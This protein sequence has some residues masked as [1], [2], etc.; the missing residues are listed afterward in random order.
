MAHAPS[1]GDCSLTFR[2]FDSIAEL[3]SGKGDL[4]ARLNGRTFPLSPDV[5]FLGNVGSH[6]RRENSEFSR[7]DVSKRQRTV[8]TSVK[9]LPYLELV[10]ETRLESAGPRGNVRGDHKLQRVAGAALI[11]LIRSGAS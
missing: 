3:A 7:I 11:D 8:E 2:L 6:L 4:L 1:G 9:S 10:A 5:A